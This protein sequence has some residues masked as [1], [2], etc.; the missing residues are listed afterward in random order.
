MRLGHVKSFPFNR[1]FSSDVWNILE[2]NLPIFLL[3]NLKYINYKH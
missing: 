1:F 2:M 3:L